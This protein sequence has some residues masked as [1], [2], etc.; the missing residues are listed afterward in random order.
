[1]P[2]GTKLTI[3]PGVVVKFG[4]NAVMNVDGTLQA[5]G[6]AGA[7]IVFTSLQDDTAGGDTA[8]PGN[9]PQRLQ[10]VPLI[11]PVLATDRFH[12]APPLTCYGVTAHRNP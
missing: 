1:M 3:Q 6:T 8:L 5:Q 9:A 11:S 4:T 12:F 10:R 2:V 7:P